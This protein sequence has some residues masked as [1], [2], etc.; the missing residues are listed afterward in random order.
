MAT[1]DK[2]RDGVDPDNSAEASRAAEPESPAATPSQRISQYGQK[3]EVAPFSLFSKCPITKTLYK[4]VQTDKQ[5]VRIF[6]VSKAIKTE[7]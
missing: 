6:L 7:D 1:I 4:L 5:L 2:E 3:N